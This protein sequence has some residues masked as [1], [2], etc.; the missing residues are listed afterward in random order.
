MFRKS[1][2]LAI[3]FTLSSTTS[4]LAQ[5]D[6]LGLIIPNLYGPQGLFVQSDAP[7]AGGVDHS[8]HF[9]SSFQSEFTQFN[10]ALA[11][12]LSALPLPS[13]ASGFTYEFD[14]A[15]GAFT[16]TTQSFGPILAERAETIGKGR[17][18]FGFYFQRFSF[19]SVEGLDLGS[20]P[21]VFT[22]D[23]AQLL[24]GREDVVTTV[25]SIETTVNQFTAFFTYGLG[26]RVDLSL[27]VPIVNSELK[28]TSVATLQRLGTTNP[29]IHYYGEPGGTTRTFSDSG[30]ASGIGDIV[31]RLKGT[32]AKSGRMGLALGVDVRFPTG[33]EEDL[34]GSGAFGLKPFA[35]LS[36]S[37]QRVSPHINLGYQW[38]GNSALASEFRFG[39]S[40]AEFGEKEDLP[41]NFLWVFGVDFGAGERVTVIFDV[42]GT[43]I[44]D[45]PQL[46]EETFTG[47]DAAGTTF[48]NIAFETATFNIVNGALGFKVN[49]GGNLL[50][51]FNLL[52]KL[53]DAGLRDDL[54]PLIGIEYSF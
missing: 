48:P 17:F 4:T 2:M 15:A 46:V 30:S 22:H 20:V 9:N 21:A 36:F 10:I 18:S 42:I 24:G 41:D 47:L 40:G 7:L 38:N 13:P 19:D 33:D 37:H 3:F 51:D 29:A 35:A 31:A 52:F 26:D 14:A 54:T 50:I 23:S 5:D 43:T 8:A 27:G 6:K 45:S 11:S 34:L 12:E 53:N 25:N 44:I 1:V 49:A 32:L 28:V 16:R 39:A